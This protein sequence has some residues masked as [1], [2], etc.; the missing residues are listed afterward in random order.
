LRDAGVPVSVL[1][2]PV[3][4]GLTDH[5]MASILK[6]AREA[7]ATSAG[8]LLLRLPHHVGP[9]FLHWLDVHRPAARGRVEA[10]IRS[11]RGG[12][13]DDSRFGCR[14]RGEA[15]YADSISASFGVFARKHGL[16]QP[17][18]ALDTSQFRPPLSSGGQRCLF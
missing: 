14:M 9:L 18:P 8:H 15:A 4:P 12:E 5:E 11:T 6:S 16:D 17:M 10:L 13:L 1:V 7:G 2:S 3:I